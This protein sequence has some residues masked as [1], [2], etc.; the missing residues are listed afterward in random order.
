MFDYVL[1]S[2]QIFEVGVFSVALLFL[3][4]RIGRKFF[5]ELFKLKFQTCFCDDFFVFVDYLVFCQLF[6][7][8]CLFF[9]L[10]LFLVLCIGDFFVFCCLVFKVPVFL[11]LC[12]R[13][14]LWF[15]FWSSLRFCFVFYYSYKSR[16][17]I[18][19][20]GKTVVFI[21]DWI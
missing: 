21:W 13:H 14:N 4:K 12:G 20:K 5:F 7:C 1:L 16:S 18:T 19:Y 9:K 15:S 11:V 17:S 3:F 2:W 6:N 10:S 8:F